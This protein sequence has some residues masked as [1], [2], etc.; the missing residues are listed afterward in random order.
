MKIARFLVPLALV[1]AAAPTCA[2]QPIR[3][4]IPASVGGGTD[5]FFRLLAKEAE[6]HLGTNVIVTNVAS[7]AGTAGVA[8]M[9]RSN[10]DGYTI[11]GVW[12]GPLTVVPH[13]MSVPYQPSDY[14]P[15][16]QLTS[17]PYVICTGAGFPADDGRALIETLRSRPGH[18]TYGTDGIGGSA[19]LAAMRIF[20][21]LGISQRDIPYKGAGETLAA[22]L[23]GHIDMYVGSLPPVI[24][25]VREGR[26]KCLLLTSA[27]KVAQ[28]P[29]ATSLGELGLGNEETLLWRAV[30]APKGTPQQRI[31]QLEQAFEAAAQAPAT[32]AFVENAGEKILL[33]KGVALRER[34]D[35][36]YR[37]LGRIAVELMTDRN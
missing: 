10:P 27:D 9:V 19:Q 1:S 30:L 8:Q 34:I 22:L 36:E 31:R 26:I 14:I 29:Q 17:A 21:P 12:T 3:M 35:E 5:S 2:A 20:R 16:L 37:V 7:A 11:A 24:R 28:L 23:G 15:V 18:Y 33:V 4:I 25:H 6:P 13:S 32:R